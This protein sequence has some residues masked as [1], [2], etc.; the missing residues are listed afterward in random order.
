[1]DTLKIVWLLG[2]VF[3]FICATAFWLTGFGDGRRWRALAVLTFSLWPLWVAGFVLFGL[4]AVCVD[5]VV[6]DS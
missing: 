3:W 4:V 2:C 1:M 5:M 6:G